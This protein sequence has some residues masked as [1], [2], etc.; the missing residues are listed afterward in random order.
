[1]DSHKLVHKYQIPIF[2]CKVLSSATLVWVVRAGFAGIGLWPL[3]SYR[4][5]PSHSPQHL[6]FASTFSQT[7]LSPHIYIYITCI[8]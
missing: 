4:V 5:A 8:A 3:P 7:S 1:M 2:F 6:L